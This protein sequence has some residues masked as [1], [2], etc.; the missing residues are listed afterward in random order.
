MVF[1]E[2]RLKINAEIIGIIMEGQYLQLL[3]PD[4]LDIKV[5]SH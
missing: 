4:Q 1:V 2:L 3:I 5:K